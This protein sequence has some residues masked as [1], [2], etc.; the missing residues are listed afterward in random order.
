MGFNAP[1]W[2]FAFYGAMIANCVPTGI[3]TT[4]N[5]EACEYQVNHCEA[6]VLVLENLTLFEK[7]VPFLHKV[8]NMKAIVIYDYDVQGIKQK[9]HD[10][11]DILF[12]FYDFLKLGSEIKE[13]TLKERTQN[14]RPGNCCNIVYTSGTTGPPKGVMLSHD[15]MLSAMK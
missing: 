11:K 7:F 9:H 8:P 3:Y 4:N 14:Q 6:E 10:F 2:A 5:T 13:E 15:N 12:N 1:E